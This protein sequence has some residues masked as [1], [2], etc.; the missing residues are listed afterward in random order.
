MKPEVALPFDDTTDFD[1]AERGFIAAG[2][3]VIHDDHGEVVWDNGSS[4]IGSPAGV[5]AAS[6]TVT[7]KS[8]IAIPR[9]GPLRPSDV[10]SRRF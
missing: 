3:S 10:S 4:A 6:S 5:G 1:N 8:P 2:V 7:A 9:T